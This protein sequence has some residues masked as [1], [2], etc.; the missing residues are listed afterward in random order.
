M[1]QIAFEGEAATAE[2]YHAARAHVVKNW[3]DL[4]HEDIGIIERMQKGRSSDGFDGGALSPYWDPVQQHY[5]RLI[6]E[7][8]GAL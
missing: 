4:N 8:I 6:T 2:K 1:L 3:N 5:A 7:S